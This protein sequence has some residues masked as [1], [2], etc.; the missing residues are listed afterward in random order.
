MNSS[1]TAYKNL[2]LPLV[3]SVTTLVQALAS[4]IVIIPA[5]LAP[6]LARAHGVAASLIGFQVSFAYIGAM[7]TSVLGGVIV[8]RYGAVRCSQLALIFAATGCGLT[9]VPTLGAVAIG[10]VF[11]GFGYGLTNPAAAHMLMK[12]TAPANR[13]LIFS[14]KQ[15]GV[16]FGGVV[17]GLL[18]PTIAVSFGWQSALLAGAIVTGLIA[19]LIQLVRKAWDTDRDSTVPLTAS[20]FADVRMVWA[21]K[22]LRWV[23]LGSFSFSAMQVSLTTFAVTMLVSDI[24]YSLVQAGVLLAVLQVAGVTGRVTWGWVADRIKD[25][26]RVLQGITVITIIGAV[27]TGLLDPDVPDA[28]VY[29]VMAIFGFT[30][31]GWNGVFMAEIARLAPSSLI[32]SATGAALFVTYSGVVLGPAAFTGIYGIV[33]TYTA[34]FG[35]FSLVA[36][37]GLVCVFLARLKR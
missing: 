25:G 5:A 29:A 11:I 1:D 33:G 24:G 9:A 10:A 35:I 23:S 31:I 16:P 4:M 21:H 18:A 28:W 7:T 2:S 26:N 13:N 14:I 22:S 32:S 15:T 3:V 20:P 8:R 12:V 6:E 17:A 37:A 30:A 34:S 36:L 27:L 19:L